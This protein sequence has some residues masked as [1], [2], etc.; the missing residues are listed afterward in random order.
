M[1]PYVLDSHHQRLRGLAAEVARDVVAPNA[2]K[3]DRDFTLPLEMLR[4][5]HRNGLLALSVPKSLGGGGCNIVLG[6]DPLAYLLVLEQ[7]GKA[8]M[9]STHCY[10]VHQHAVQMLTIGATAEQQRRY[11]EPIVDAGE[12]ISWTA[13][14]P[15]GTARGHYSMLTRAEPTADGLV[16]TG[17][18]T[19]GT[20]ASCAHWT[21]YHASLPDRP[22][23]QDMIMFMVPRGAPGVVIDESW[24]R[25]LG[26]RA[27][28]SPRVELNAVQVPSR[29]I[30]QD[31]GFYARE[32]YGSRWHLAFGAT[33][34]GAATG[35]LE[36]ICDYLPQ[37]GTSAN[38]HSQ[39]TV[40]EMRMQVE[41]ARSLLYQAA[42]Y[43]T[44]SDIRRAEEFSLMA[45]LFAMSTAEWI[46]TEAI[47]VAGSSALFEQHPLS[48]QIRNIHV[49]STHAN[50][51]NTAQT[52]GRA[53]MG[54]EFDPANQQ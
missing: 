8:D 43:W 16:V 38:P 28:V 34:L 11:F 7:L 37:R 2:A 3:H 6:E 52:I 23:P 20:L 12:V 26:M 48:R 15:G 25:P 47:R 54:L 41:A 9:A 36:F 42:S 46:T 40:G 39:R 30:I 4:A 13:T 17:E 31:G 33:H 49:Q 1:Q 10:Q 50:L 45:K 5:L 35:I 18:K 29:D 19:Y 27:A 24:W 22:M 14:E 32:N 44:G 21:L 51:H 53:L